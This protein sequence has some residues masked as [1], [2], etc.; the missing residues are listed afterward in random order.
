MLALL[1]YYIIIRVGQRRRG[2]D[3]SLRIFTPYIFETCTFLHLASYVCTSIYAYV[4]RLR[5]AC[6]TTLWHSE[7]VTL[8]NI[9]K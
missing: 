4:V 1:F 2:V 8:I 5:L 6:D 3:T 7:W 9:L